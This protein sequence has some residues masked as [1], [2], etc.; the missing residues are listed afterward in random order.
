ML[1]SSLDPRQL[2]KAF[3]DSHPAFFQETPPYLSMFFVFLA[4]I[5]TTM[6]LQSMLRPR[7]VQVYD[8]AVQLESLPQ[9]QDDLDLH[10]LKYVHGLKQ[11]HYHSRY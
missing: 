9:F 11:E 5:G 6:L 2:G 4:G 7:P 1:T 8:P 10:E 3:V